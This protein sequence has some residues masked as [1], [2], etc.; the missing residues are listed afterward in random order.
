MTLTARFSGT[1]HE[2]G[3]RWQPGDLIRADQPERGVL[4]IWQH[5]T[6]P[7]TP[8]DRDAQRTPC[9]RC[10]LIHPKGTCDR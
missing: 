6:C 3:Q 5:A 8:D 1:C 4:P 9:E 10:F 7:E 2:C